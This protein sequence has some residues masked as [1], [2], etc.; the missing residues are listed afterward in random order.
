MS[1][2]PIEDVERRS[3][4]IG[5]VDKVLNAQL[6]LTDSA[7]AG[8]THGLTKTTISDVTSQSSNGPSEPMDQGSH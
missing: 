1:W 4:E 8:L 2:T 3:Q 6:A 5:L 7:T